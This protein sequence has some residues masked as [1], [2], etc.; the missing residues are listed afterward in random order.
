[1]GLLDKWMKAAGDND[2]ELVMSLYSDNPDLLDKR[3]PNTGRT[4]L[5]HASAWNAFDVVGFLLE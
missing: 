5:Q 1:M 4:A 3:H 2:L